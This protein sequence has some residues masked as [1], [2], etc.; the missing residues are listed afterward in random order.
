MN[1]KCPVASAT[2]F[3]LFNAKAMVCAASGSSLS[4]AELRI[5][6]SQPPTMAVYQTRSAVFTLAMLYLRAWPCSSKMGFGLA[7][8]LLKT[9]GGVFAITEQ[10]S[11]IHVPFSYLF[12]VVAQAPE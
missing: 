6:Y 10:H 1:S 8:A 9:S 7:G 3:L 2:L 11:V 4:M 5:S 12:A